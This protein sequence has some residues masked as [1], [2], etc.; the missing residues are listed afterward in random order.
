MTQPHDMAA[1]LLAGG[2]LRIV[3]VVALLGV[4]AT[5]AVLLRAYR[6]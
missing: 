5:A 2:G 1:P 6:K 4:A 3:L